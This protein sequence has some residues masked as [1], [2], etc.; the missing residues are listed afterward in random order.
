MTKAILAA[1]FVLVFA[2]E[3]Y[4]QGG[5]RQ[6]GER[7][8]GGDARRLCKKVLGQGDNAVLSCLVQNQRRISGA[9]RRVLRENGQL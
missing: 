4:A 2:A 1:A 8:C 5:S 9:C 6:M 7:A 3:A